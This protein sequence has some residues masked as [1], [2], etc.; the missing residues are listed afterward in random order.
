MFR[1]V[2]TYKLENGTYISELDNHSG[3]IGDTCTLKVDGC[4]VT[5]TIVSQYEFYLD[6]KITEC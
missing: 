3:N 5:G 1:V 4:W 6:G 2:I